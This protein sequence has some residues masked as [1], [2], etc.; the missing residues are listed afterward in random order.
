MFVLIS[1]SY[2]TGCPSETLQKGTA[3]KKKNSRK[4]SIRGSPENLIKSAVYQRNKAKQL[5][6]SNSLLGTDI[7][8]R[9]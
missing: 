6:C 3:K 1:Y 2:V 4:N 9:K 5:S 8:R 7:F